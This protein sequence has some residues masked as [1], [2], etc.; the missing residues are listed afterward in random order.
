[1]IGVGVAAS[2]MCRQDDVA[3]GHVAVGKQLPYGAASG[4][5]LPCY[6]L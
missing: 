6:V 4:F 1:M 3:D 5:K 2:P